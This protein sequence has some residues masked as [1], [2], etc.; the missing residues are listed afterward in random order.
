MA[1]THEK[2]RD[3]LA[4]ERE[5]RM[6]AYIKATGERDELPADADRFSLRRAEARVELA[7]TA[8]REWG[9]PDPEVVTKSAAPEGSSFL[10]AVRPSGAAE[11]A[12]TVAARILASDTVPGEG[13]R[14]ATVD[15]IA[16]RIA[17]A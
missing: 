3:S 14:D 17:G 7:R 13:R 5:A 16:A 2:I 1:R 15:A 8:M 10:S 11:T 9:D 12:E 6:A 4:R